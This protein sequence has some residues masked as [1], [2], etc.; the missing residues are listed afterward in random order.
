MEL[1]S[2]WMLNDTDDRFMKHA[3]CKGLDRSMFFPER[4]ANAVIK[5]AK[6]VC[7]SCP[8]QED[9]LRFAMNNRIQ[10]GVWG[11]TTAYQRIK[12]W[13]RKGTK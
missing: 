1:F 5:K 7:A 8:V 6:A 12:R 9:C 4:G 3:A 10:F 2:E 13:S 11:G